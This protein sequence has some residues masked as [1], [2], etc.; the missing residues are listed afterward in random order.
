MD[1]VNYYA[2]LGLEDDHADEVPMTTAVKDTMTMK[3]YEDKNI[4]YMV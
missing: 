2:D 3:I 1:I 4:I